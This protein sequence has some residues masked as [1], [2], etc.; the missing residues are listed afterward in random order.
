MN[1]ETILFHRT[2][3]VARIT[4]NRPER[5]NALSGRMLQELHQALDLAEADGGSRVVLLTAAGRVFCAGADLKQGI[6][7]DAQGVPDLG[8][9]L[10]RDFNPLVMRLR[11]LGIPVMCAVNGVAAGAGVSLAMAADI[12]VAAESARFD[13]AFT[14]LGLIPDAGSTH[15]LPQ[16]IGMA[17]AMGLALLGD[18]VDGATAAAWGLIWRCVANEELEG[19]TQQLASRLANAPTLAL[20][21]TKKVLYAS[22]GRDL[23][24][25]LEL[26]AE[27]QKSA[28]MTADFQEGLAAFLNKRPAHF[29]GR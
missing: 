24:A 22:S 14:R 11:G 15:F 20:G 18:S 28:G 25:Q 17:R 21:L 27:L 26:E 23:A 2:D 8:A 13:L 7:E 9:A 3:N 12:I 29:R 1:F 5:L 4:L 19:V 6:F 16:R 10:S